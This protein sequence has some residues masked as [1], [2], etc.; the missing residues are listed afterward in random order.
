MNLT[1]RHDSSDDAPELYYVVGKPYAITV[2][3]EDGY[4]FNDKPDRLSKFVNYM[5]ELFLSSLNMYGIAYEIYTELSEPKEVK[6]KAGGSRLH[7]HGV[8]QF[9]STDQVRNFLLHSQYKISQV[10]QTLY[11]EVTDGK[12]W[13]D[14]CLKQQKIMRVSPYKSSTIKINEHHIKK[15]PSKN[16]LDAFQQ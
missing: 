1:T 4:Q 15:Q 13:N 14:Y 11:K 5:N 7:C 2:N 3:P 9:N 6:Y 10:G 12:G 16:I 8:I